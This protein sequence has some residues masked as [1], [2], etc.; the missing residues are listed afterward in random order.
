VT[1][2]MSFFISMNNESE[3]HQNPTHELLSAVKIESVEHANI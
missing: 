1:L 3:S 2:A